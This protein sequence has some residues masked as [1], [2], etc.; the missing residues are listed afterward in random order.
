MYFGTDVRSPKKDGWLRVVWGSRQT[1]VAESL[2]AESRDLSIPLATRTDVLWSSSSQIV[3]IRQTLIMLV[4]EIKRVMEDLLRSGRSDAVGFGLV[5]V[6]SALDVVD[7]SPYF[8]Y[9]H[10]I[11]QISGT[12]LP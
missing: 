1:K 8:T 2:N 10:D 11:L 6:S 7:H 5:S 3:Q 12:R 4:L 9:I